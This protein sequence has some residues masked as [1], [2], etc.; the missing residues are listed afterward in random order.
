[1]GDFHLTSSND[2]TF[3]IRPVSARGQVW[4]ESGWIK[5]YI[6]DNTI[7]DFAIILTKNQKVVCDEIRKNNF[8]FSN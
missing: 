4:W 5:K 6:V 2:G 7:N 3:L 1:M 8:D